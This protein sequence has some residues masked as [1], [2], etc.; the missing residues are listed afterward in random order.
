[1]VLIWAKI[2]TIEKHF[3]RIV[4][5]EQLS[6][7]HSFNLQKDDLNIDYNLG[8]ALPFRYQKSN[9]GAAE[10]EVKSLADKDGNLINTR[11]SGERLGAYEHDI[12]MVWCSMAKEQ[13]REGL[14]QNREGKLRVHYTVSH[15]CER[16]RLSKNTRSRVR[17][18][19]NNLL[20]Y[21]VKV[22]NFAF[23]RATEEMDY[24]DETISLI[25]KHGEVKRLVTSNGEVLSTGSYYVEFDESIIEN[26]TLGM[27]SVV[28]EDQ[29]FNLKTGID[30]RALVFL[31]SK[32]KAFGN[33][34]FFPIS[35]LSLVLG[36]EQKPPRKQRERIIKA[37]D[38]AKKVSNRFSYEILKVHNRDEWDV[39]I[40]FIPEDMISPPEVDEFYQCLETIYTRE[41]LEKFDV[42][43]R[44][45][46]IIV[47]EINKKWCKDS[48]KEKPECLFMG[49]T[50]VVGEYILDLALHQVI[51]TNYSLTGSIKLLAKAIYKALLDDRLELPD[52][53][54][55]FARKQAKE[56]EKKHIMKKMNEQKEKRELI[57]NNKLENIKKG[58]EFAYDSLVDNN[59]KVK[60]EIE[61]IAIEI[62]SLEGIEKNNPAFKLAFD[63]KVKDLCF[64]RYQNGSL[65]DSFKIN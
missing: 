14:V 4:M 19:I 31:N 42:T 25:S 20:N 32:R 63:K 22:K 16:L 48:G 9:K 30:R 39:L 38:T 5:E 52:K 61:E 10:V 26:L 40:E 54:R 45:V 33:K 62:L 65:L 46:K 11:M 47:D 57:E 56:I 51:K 58:F 35:E 64:D 17:S 12:L 27:V 3:P 24:K 41:S 34:Y 28:N 18:A 8:L 2:I 23:M 43:E 29:Y 1:M 55:Y 7:A 50:V 59:P 44:D 36:L 49:D 15:L 37:L 6:L 53:Y 21:K 60:A 13:E